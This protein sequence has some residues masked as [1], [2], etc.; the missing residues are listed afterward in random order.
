MATAPRR[1]G[2]ESSATRALILSAAETV[3]REEGYAAT[4]TRRV[5]K[6]AGLKPSLVH[7]YFPTTDDLLL[8]V[9]RKGAEESD[10]WLDE[11]LASPD[12]LRALWK[13]LT[14]TSR[15]ELALETMALANHRKAIRAEIAAHSERMRARQ[16]EAF[17]RVLG[18]KLAGPEACPP[19]ALSLILAGIGRALIME[20]AFGVESGH[21]EA[22]GYVERMIERMMAPAKG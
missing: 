21:A 8:A 7:Y 19:A 15:T 17:T 6:Q 13:L 22:K 12:P 20:G 4:S 11:A 18:G 9:F 14:D 5:A 16:V 1:V 10:A 3:M 2:A